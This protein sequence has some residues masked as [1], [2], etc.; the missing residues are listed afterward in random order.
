[1]SAVPA[2]HPPHGGKGRSYGDRHSHTF[3]PTDPME[4]SPAPE[5]RLASLSDNA[6]TTLANQSFYPHPLPS[7][8]EA[9]TIAIAPSPTPAMCAEGV[10]QERVDLTAPTRTVQPRNACTTPWTSAVNGVAG[11][12]TLLLWPLWPRLD[13]VII[14]PL[15]LYRAL[16]A[17]AVAQAR[18]KCHRYFLLD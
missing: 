11:T 15:Y 14:L 7:P 10:Q 8:C 4:A 3:S 17:T 13:Y 18:I 5:Q 9:S 6:E 1:M 12:I 2:P 16:L